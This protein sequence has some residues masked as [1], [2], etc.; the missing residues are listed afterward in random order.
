MTCTRLEPI[1]QR[2]IDD[3]R[4]QAVRRST[5]CRPRM[6]APYSLGSNQSLPRSPMH[7]SRTRRF[8][9]AP[10][11]PSVCASFARKTA[12]AWCRS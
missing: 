5:R 6:L 8:R 9:S 4:P 10:K 3:L 1:T 2:F 11:V 12:N 7:I